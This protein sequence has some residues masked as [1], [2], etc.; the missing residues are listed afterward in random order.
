MSIQQAQ[1]VTKAFFLL[2]LSRESSKSSSKTMFP[3]SYNTHII[4]FMPKCVYIS[5][6]INYLY[7]SKKSCQSDSTRKQSQQ[8][9]SPHNVIIFF[10]KQ[11]KSIAEYR[12]IIFE[13]T[14]SEPPNIPTT[15]SQ[16]TISEHLATQQV[17]RRHS[18]QQ[19]HAHAHSH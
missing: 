19:A 11:S 12:Y 1:W 5:N 10:R 16:H 18:T 6:F 9:N 13:H 14:I 4:Q 8:Y 3:I 15:T 17:T 7:Y 2:G